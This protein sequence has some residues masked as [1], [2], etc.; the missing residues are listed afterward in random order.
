MKR[1]SR[2]GPTVDDLLENWDEQSLPGDAPVDFNPLSSQLP[3]NEIHKPYKPGD[4]GGEIFGW[5]LTYYDKVG[6]ELA[7]VKKAGSGS[8]D[9]GSFRRLKEFSEKLSEALKA[10]EGNE[11]R[12]FGTGKE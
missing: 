4:G 5:V 1:A 6:D 12:W 7:N 8:K 2:G 11:D 3:V 10:L 9:P